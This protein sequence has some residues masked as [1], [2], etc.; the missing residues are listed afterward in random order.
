M[1]LLVSG[2]VGVGAR[3]AL[4]LQSLLTSVPPT[5][6]PDME[7]RVYRNESLS[8]HDCGANLEAPQQVFANQRVTSL[9]W[10]SRHPHRSSPAALKTLTGTRAKFSHHGVKQSSF[11]GFNY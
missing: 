2:L 5:H 7:T 11:T 1:E 6:D 3:A 8:S 10:L 9:N 4:S